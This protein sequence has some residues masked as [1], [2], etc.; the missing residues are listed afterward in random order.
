L[1]KIFFFKRNIIILSLCFGFFLIKMGNAAIAPVGHLPSVSVGVTPSIYALPIL[2]V[3]KR[4]E[5]ADFGIQINL[6][7]YRTGEEQLDRAVGNEWEVGIMDPFNAIKGGNEGNLVI[8][9]VAGN[10]AKH[11]PFLLKEE[12]VFFN[13]DKLGKW[14]KAF[15]SEKMTEGE[16][17]FLPGCLVAI[18]NY[19]DTRKT[20]VIRW[21]EGYL[22]GL[23]IMQENREEAAGVLQA[24]YR[25][26]LEVE[27][28]KAILQQELAKAFFFEEKNIDEIFRVIGG[29]ASAFE[30]TAHSLT[31]YLMMSKDLEAKEDPKEYTLFK[32]IEQLSTIRKEALSQLEKTRLAI[33]EA[34]KAGTNVEEFRKVWEEARGQIR[35]G[36]GYLRIIGVLSGLQRKAE[37]AR[38]AGERLQNLRKIELIIG[39]M[40]ALYYMGY[41]LYRKKRNGSISKLPSA[42][43]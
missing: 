12:S 38:V 24:F 14:A 39:I 9:G 17:I 3:E 27:F 32:L 28:P 36:R 4:G 19:A 23:R 8:V 10:F 1:Q 18:T 26:K 33:E 30:K 5:W 31:N 21:L 42:Q 34:A 7:I 35:E 40:L 22:R 37:Q 25:E 20:L 15:K 13:R 2:L 41:A 43:F 29:E 11:L 16:N 6:K